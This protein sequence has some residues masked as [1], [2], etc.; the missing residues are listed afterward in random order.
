MVTPLASRN[1]LRY[2]SPKKWRPN[3]ALDWVEIKTKTVV[4]VV[5]EMDT[6]GR[7]MEGKPLVWVKKR[8]KLQTMGQHWRRSRETYWGHLGA[9][10]LKSSVG[11]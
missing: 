4:R 11:R 6:A 1:K 8:V 10:P 3:I 5:T 2:A 7:P 9:L